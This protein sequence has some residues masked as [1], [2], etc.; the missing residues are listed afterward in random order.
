MTKE[1]LK[2]GIIAV[3]A[4]LALSTVTVG[5]AISPAQ[6]GT[7]QASQAVRG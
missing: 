7:V 3:T 4:A 6:A 5:A 1:T 2:T